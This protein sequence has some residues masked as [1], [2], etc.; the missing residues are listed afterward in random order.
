VRGE[1]NGPQHI[2]A[3]TLVAG[4]NPARYQLSYSAES[5]GAAGQARTYFANCIARSVQDGSKEVPSYS[6]PVRVRRM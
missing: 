5:H 3:G 6:R 4:T 2:G 1:G